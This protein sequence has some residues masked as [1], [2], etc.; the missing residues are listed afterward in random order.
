MKDKWLFSKIDKS[1]LKS[2]MLWGAFAS[3]VLAGLCATLG[4]AQAGIASKNNEMAL[5]LREITAFDPFTLKTPIFTRR[6]E[7]NPSVVILQDG[8]STGAM[9]H[10]AIRIPYRPVPRSPFRPPLVPVAAP[11]N[12]SG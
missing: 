5:K 12:L 10:P 1:G 7:D 11:I 2:I 8:V 9:E 4:A 6:S 3:A